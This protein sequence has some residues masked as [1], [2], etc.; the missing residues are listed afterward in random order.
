MALYEFSVD[1][2][3][4]A[5]NLGAYGRETISVNGEV[6]SSKRVLFS[7]NSKHA[8]DLVYRDKVRRAVISISNKWFVVASKL[9]VNGNLIY[10]ESKKKEGTA[11]WLDGFM[12][13]LL[14]LPILFRPPIHPIDWM[15]LPFLGCIIIIV[16]TIVYVF[17][18]SI[19]S[20]WRLLHGEGIRDIL[21]FRKLVFLIL[22]SCVLPL[23]LYNSHLN[24]VEIDAYGTQVAEETQESCTTDLVCPVA[25]VGWIKYE[26][27]ERHY[28]MKKGY[29]RLIYS[30]DFERTEFILRVYHAFDDELIF[31]GGVLKDL[32]R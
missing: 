6:V 8:F 9:K 23:G 13:L 16:Y 25:P 22:A 5:I 20:G 26:T 28:F 24:R 19:R 2:S 7:R 4:W 32:E 1:G 15:M 3:T 29:M 30:T 12:L 21:F 11:A 14:V 18:I 31:S 27:G 10:K 17:D